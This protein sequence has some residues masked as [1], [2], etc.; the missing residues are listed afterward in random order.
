MKCYK[1]IAGNGPSYDP[2]L[3]MGLG[4]AV[5]GVRLK[6]LL[7]IAAVAVL[8]FNATVALSQSADDVVRLVTADTGAVGNA[9]AEYCRQ[10]D[11][12]QRDVQI[13]VGAGFAQSHLYFIS[14]GDQ[15]N[16]G[17]IAQI[18]CTC[19]RTPGEILTSF[20]ATL[21]EAEDQACSS[22]WSVDRSGS[23]PSLFQTTVS[24]SSSSSQ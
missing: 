9:V 13:G 22:T 16:A 15:L 24:S 2:L 23:L 12:A 19:E 6:R 17:V 3:D 10:A 20:L 11:E 21:G 8:A 7:S 14:V 1:W 5:L 18:A 4:L